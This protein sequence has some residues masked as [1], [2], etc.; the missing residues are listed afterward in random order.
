MSNSHR[1]NSNSSNTYSN[2]TI[3]VNRCLYRV[4]TM[5][6]TEMCKIPKLRLYEHLL[7]AQLSKNRNCV[8]EYLI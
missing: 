5:S 6:E 2:I 3:V 8:V 7:I 4:K 1:N